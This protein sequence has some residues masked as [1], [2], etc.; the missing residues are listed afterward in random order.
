MVLLAK[1]A[2]LIAL[3]TRLH[4][5]V[6][7]GLNATVLLANECRMEWSA[8]SDWC[9]T[10]IAF[11]GRRNMARQYKS[12]VVADLRLEPA[13]SAIETGPLNAQTNDYSS[14]A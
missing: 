10:A 7:Q 1:H 5:R 13:A 14:S 8:T 2:T 6:L 11:V 3:Q 4:E 12:S 9:S